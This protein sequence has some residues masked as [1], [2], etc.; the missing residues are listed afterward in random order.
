MSVSLKCCREQLKFTCPLWLL[1]IFVLRNSFALGFSEINF[2]EIE[3][4][5]CVSNEVLVLISLCRLEKRGE[6]FFVNCGIWELYEYT[7]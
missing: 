6:K 5:S 4:L 3:L 1:E 2:K 7:L